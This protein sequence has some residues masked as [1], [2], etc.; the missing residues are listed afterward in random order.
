MVPHKSET[1]KGDGDEM[2][3]AEGRIHKTIFKSDYK[4]VTFLLDR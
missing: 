3:V 4:V 2:E 1:K